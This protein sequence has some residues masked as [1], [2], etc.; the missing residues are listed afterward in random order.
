ME[1]NGFLGVF[2][3]WDRMLCSDVTISQVSCTVI[4]H[5]FELHYVNLSDRQGPTVYSESIQ[6]PL[7]HFVTLQP[8]SKIDLKINTNP[9]FTHNTP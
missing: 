9:Q 1:L 4:P 3:V 8:G 5:T 6:T 2:T 7:P